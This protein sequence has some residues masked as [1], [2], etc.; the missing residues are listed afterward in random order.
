MRAP[1]NPAETLLNYII[2]HTDLYMRRKKGVSEDALWHQAFRAL[3]PWLAAIL[4]KARAE[5][6]E[7][8]AQI[9]DAR[10]ADICAAQIRSRP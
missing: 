4:T 9:C 2:H 5:E 3:S 7:A 1:M 10:G 8:C 6:R